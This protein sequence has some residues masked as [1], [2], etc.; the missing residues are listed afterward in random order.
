[1]RPHA[2]ASAACRVRAPRS[3]RGQPAQGAQRE[4]RRRHIRGFGQVEAREIGEAA[5]LVEHRV[6]V[7]VQELGCGGCDPSPV[8][9]AH[10]VCSRSVRHFRSRRRTPTGCSPS[11]RR[12]CEVAPVAAALAN[13]ADLSADM[14]RNLVDRWRS[15]YP[16]RRSSRPLDSPG[17]TFQSRLALCLAQVAPC[18][19][20]A[21]TLVHRVCGPDFGVAV[22]AGKWMPAACR[23][24]VRRSRWTCT[25]I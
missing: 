3:G 4:H 9:C 18:S 25:C 11:W 22:Y 20:S 10:T 13:S 12:C 6:A 2:S 15:G 7:P 14:R 24:T 16:A 1:M 8:R 19:C 17:P 5:Q 23:R 21:C